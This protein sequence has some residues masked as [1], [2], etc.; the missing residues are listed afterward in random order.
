MDRITNNP[1]RILGVFSNAT[2]ME[3]TANKTKR[4]RFAS[5]GKSVALDADMDSVLPPV[6]RSET[7]IEKAFADLSLPKDKLKH[8]LF[9]FVKDTNFDEMAL[10][11]LNAGDMGKAKEILGKKETWSSLINLG[12]LAMVQGDYDTA[13]N[14]IARFHIIDGFNLR[15]LS[16]FL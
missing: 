15:P 14:H 13:V 12:V 11:H 5:V 3:I 9:W 8:A 7:S 4:A 10:G 1:Y 6:D 16:C 2:I